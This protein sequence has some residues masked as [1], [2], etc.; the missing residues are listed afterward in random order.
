MSHIKNFKIK[1]I[2][3]LVK[4]VMITSFTIQT[5]SDMSKIQLRKSFQLKMFKTFT[6]LKKALKISSMKT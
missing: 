2:N 1:L 4:E 6:K 5:M 3:H